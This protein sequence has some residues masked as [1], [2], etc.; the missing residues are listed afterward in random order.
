MSYDDNAE[1][2]VRII[3][4]NRDRYRTALTNP[5]VLGAVGPAD[6]LSVLVS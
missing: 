3:R 6:G 4:E 2:W 1:F 5:A